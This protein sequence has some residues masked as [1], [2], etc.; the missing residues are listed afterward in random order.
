MT[1]NA[2]VTSPAMAI[3]EDHLA[4]EEDPIAAV[5]LAGAGLPVLRDAA[6]EADP[7]EDLPGTPAGA[8]DPISPGSN[9]TLFEQAVEQNSRRLLAIARAIVGYRASPEDVVQQAI[10]NLYKHRARYDWRKPGG[11]LKRATVNEALR[12]LRPPRMT[13]VADDHPAAFRAPSTDMETSETVRKVRE[14]IDQLPD[15]F[16]AALVLCEY[17]GMS[18][19]QI[20]ETLDASIPQ[21]K[22]WLH[23]ARR[24]LATILEPFVEQQQQEHTR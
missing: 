23:R 8:D 2:P 21:I 14:A 20:A 16:R 22:T 18:Y 1:Y 15:H 11:L 19:A 3:D 12:L 6:L 17:E 24:K 9:V 10:M 7:L 4:M 5:P 13:M